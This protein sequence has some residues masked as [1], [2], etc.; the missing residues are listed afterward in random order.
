MKKL[1]LP[2][3]LGLVV[4][5]GGVFAYRASTASKARLDCPD[6]PD[7]PGSIVCP[8]TGEQVSRDHCPLAGKKIENVPD[9]C[10]QAK[11]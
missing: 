7:C 6:C 8:I 2:A 5:A 4:L 3:A 1:I 11:P 9:C 10:K